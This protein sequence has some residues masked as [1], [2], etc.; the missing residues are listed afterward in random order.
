MPLQTMC[1]SLVTR[2][3]LYRQTQQ[4]DNAEQL[5]TAWVSDEV[6]SR[7]E[8]EGTLSE[9]RGYPPQMF[10]WLSPP[11]RVGCMH[12]LPFLYSSAAPPAKQ[13]RCL[14]SSQVKPRSLVI[15]CLQREV[16][17]RLEKEGLLVCYLGTLRSSF[18]FYF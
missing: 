16:E 12:C 2:L 11:C 8:T 15:K 4:Q 13:T 9:A 1:L 10:P 14:F 17:Q 5:M 6:G 18:F 7:K 3:T